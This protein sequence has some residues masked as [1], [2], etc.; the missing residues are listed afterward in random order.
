VLIASEIQS[1][2]TSQSNLQQADESLLNSDPVVLIKSAFLVS[3]LMSTPGENTGEYVSHTCCLV[4]PNL[5][6]M[7]QLLPAI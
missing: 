3:A 4:S 5:Q 6:K 1:F 2:R 7:K